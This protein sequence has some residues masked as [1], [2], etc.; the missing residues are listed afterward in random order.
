MI[1][2]VLQ[3][4]HYSKIEKTDESATANLF[5]QVVGYFLLIFPLIEL[6]GLY[7]YAY[8]RS[9]IWAVKISA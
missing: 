6:R 4:V 9:R 2:F 8:K 7:L 3:F 1:I 5:E